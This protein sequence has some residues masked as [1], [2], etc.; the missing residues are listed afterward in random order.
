MKIFSVKTKCRLN[1]RRR[2]SARK[3]GVFAN[4]GE[5]YFFNFIFIIARPNN[6]NNKSY[7]FARSTVVISVLLVSRNKEML[8]HI[9]V[10]RNTYVFLHRGVNL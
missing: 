2:T 7:L 1:G 8:L 9:M 10:G 3:R 4:H 6:S 5:H